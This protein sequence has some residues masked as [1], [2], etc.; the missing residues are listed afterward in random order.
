MALRGS[1]VHKNH[2]HTLHIYR[3]ISPLTIFFIFEVY[4]TK[5]IE[6]KLG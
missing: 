1:A 3:V 5:G 6:M 2:N 4:S